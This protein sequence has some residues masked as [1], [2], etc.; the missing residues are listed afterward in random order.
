MRHPLAG[1]PFLALALLSPAARGQDL[2]DV[3]NPRSELESLAFELESAVARVSQPGNEPILGAEPTRGYYVPGTGG[4][5]VI[6]ARAVPR[7]PRILAGR[8][9]ANG[10]PV[11]DEA[12]RADP[13][14]A[15]LLQLL[16]PEG[17]RDAIARK[18]LRARA[19][20]E[21]AKG[22][23][24][25]RTPEREAEIKR[26]EQQ[27]EAFQRE[28]ERERQRWERDL[29]D[30]ERALQHRLQPGIEPTT[31]PGAAFAMG[32]GVPGIQPWRFWFEVDDDDRTAEQIMKDVQQAIASV[33][34]QTQTR[35]RNVGS[36]EYLSVAV[37]FLP[38]GVLADSQ[39]PLRTLVVRVRKSLLEDRQA[40][41]L[42]PEAFRAKLEISGY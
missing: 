41:R 28:V 29:T 14:Y 36:S 9:Q 24:Q 22:A 2:E 32:G 17:A 30:I 34:E 39:R 25:K 38:R 40:G 13:E 21:L 20:R 23:R 12:I 16:G 18:Q 27:V 19:E 6:P 37:D 4:V 11:N 26:I 5:F 1:Y 42:T 31:M 3:T 33:L 7:Q 10:A 15:E 35:V 8:T